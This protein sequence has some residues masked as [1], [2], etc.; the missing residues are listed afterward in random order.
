MMTVIVLKNV[1]HEVDV[2]KDMFYRR[3]EN[4]KEQ[5]FALMHELEQ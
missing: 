2:K 1:K 5:I 4:K 3:V